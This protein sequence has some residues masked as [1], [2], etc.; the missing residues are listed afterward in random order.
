MGKHL[1]TTIVNYK[2]NLISHLNKQYSFFKRWRPNQTFSLGH[3][4]YGWIPPHFFS[5]LT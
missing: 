1:I 5:Y 4:L 3:V 2:F